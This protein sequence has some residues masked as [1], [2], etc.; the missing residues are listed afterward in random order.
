LF[1]GEWHA[2]SGSPQVRFARSLRLP[3]LAERILA[4]FSPQQ[5]QLNFQ[6]RMPNEQF[7]TVRMI[8]LRIQQSCHNPGSVVLFSSL[9]PSYSAAPLMA[10]VA[11]CLAEREERVLLV[12]AVSP[13]HA[14]LPMG[15]LLTY[16]N[17]AQRTAKAAGSGGQQIDEQIKAGHHYPGL[18][19]YLSEDCEAVGELIRPTGCPGVDLIASGRSGFAREAMAS[20]CLTELLNTCR[21]NYTMV[22][23]L[24][25]AADRV[26]DLQMLTARADG[27]VL[28][29]TKSAGKD[30]RARAAVQ[31]LLELGAPVIG[32]VA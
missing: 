22:L 13:D 27:I 32:L 8:T 30:P 5:R 15:K 23:V 9:D 31:D 1:L 6:D 26:A 10:A 29:A 18:S 11:E 19:E 17:D 16:S 3:V 14:L 2:Q 28:A 24:G 25:P 12:D 21:R 4:D 20:S 7:E